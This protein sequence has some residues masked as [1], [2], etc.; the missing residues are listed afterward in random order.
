MA[1]CHGCGSTLDP[2]QEEVNQGVDE[3]LEASLKDAIKH[4]EICPLCGHSKAV[5]ASHRKSVQ[6]GLLLVVLIVVSGLA[7]AYYAYRDTERQAAVQEAL[8]QLQLNS[9]VKQLLGTP[10]TLQGKILGQVKKDETGWH[11]VRL[12][13]PVHGPKA[14]GVAQISGGRENGPWKFTTLEVVVAKEHKRVDLITGKVVEFSPDAYEEVHTQPGLAPEY[15]PADA[16]PP[17]WNGEFPCVFAV[18]GPASAPQIGSCAEPVPMTLASR[19]PVDRLEADL[20]TGKFILRQ[21]DL[22]ISEAGIQVPL[23]RTYTA[24]DWIHRNHMH[25]FGLNANHPYD[26]APLGTRNPYTE[27]FLALEDSDFLY[28]PRASKGTG[29]TDAVYRHTETSTSF[30]KATTRWD[31]NGWEMKLQDSSMIHFPESYNAKNMAQGAPTEMTDTKGNKIQLVRDPKRNLKEILTPGGRSIKFT[32]DDHD[33]IVRAQDDREQWVNYRYDSAGR[34]TD[35]V[36]SIGHARHYTYDG[37][38]LTWV[39]D[40]KNRMLIHNSYEGDWLVQQGFA[41]GDVYRYNYHLSGNSKYAEQAT[42][43]L[44]DGSVR[45]LRTGDSVSEFVKRIR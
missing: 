17:R 15:A 26:I 3:I 20:R 8:E 30:Y 5:P 37:H 4:G 32:Y 24:Q 10:I 39:R 12:S 38:L 34:L 7:V 2:T 1:T 29:Y 28:F 40:E 27:Q 23:T 16:P 11:E 44:P 25:A 31:G 45:T 13:I 18:A 9:D 6:F 22:F 42:I 43:T 21:T 19:T 36:N 33:R 41:N 35:V 14:D